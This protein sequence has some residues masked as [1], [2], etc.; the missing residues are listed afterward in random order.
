M[1]NDRE[2]IRFVCI[3]SKKVDKRATVRNAIKR[4]A[5][6]VMQRNISNIVPVDLIMIG[7]SRE[8]MVQKDSA[9]RRIYDVLSGQGLIYPQ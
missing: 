7:K 6:D 9:S 1:K 3:V 4:I 2:V 5:H 8:I